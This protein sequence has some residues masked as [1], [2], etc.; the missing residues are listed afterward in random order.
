MAQ[1][2]LLI[3]T[4]HF[5]P[6]AASG[7]F[8]LLGFARHLPK[9]GWRALVVAPPRMPWE[10][11]DPELA[12]QVPSETAIYSVPYFEGRLTTPLRMWAS[13]TPW[14]VRAWPTCARAVR[15]HQP[16]AIL[17]S[18]PPHPIHMLGLWLKRR[19][20]LP[21]IADFRDPWIATAL[22]PPRRSVTSRWE[23][24]QER[25]VMASA[26]VIITNAPNA[27]EALAQAFPSAR[28]K[29]VV[30]T[31]GYDPE[32]FE[33]P[34]WTAP[35]A[36]DQP[37]TILHPG[38]LYAGRDP[39]P[40]LDALKVFRARR[41]EQARPIRLFL[42]GN[43]EGDHHS[44]DL[45]AEIRSRDL[46]AIV[47]VGGQ[48]PYDESLKRMVR[49]DILLLLDTPGRRIGVPAKLYEYVGAGRPVL[50]LGE[51]DG[52]TA[53]VLRQCGV[54][55]RIAPPGEPESIQQA[56][57]ELV[58]QV[59]SRRAAAVGAWGRLAFT[60]EHLARQLAELL[61]FR[62][63]RSSSPTTDEVE[64]GSNPAPAPAGAFA[65]ECKSVI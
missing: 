48:V 41:G 45:A 47:S 20:R 54:P 25:A 27:C 3:V 28:E 50:A 26:D 55:Y 10:P 49:S 2:S 57:A 59:E 44:F 5:P 15:E 65:G 31:N 16:A 35:G 12:K 58:E 39:R 1:R 7:S 18:G 33:S 37:I 23:A 46:Q 6:S 11:V 36:D 19:Y 60:R 62:T 42:I 63:A 21:W 40:F 9:F 38:Q 29:I 4:F 61:N 34:E 43:L 32:R 56:L 22:S 24:R 52:D 53:W 17:T 64:S 30:I 13:F 51:P 8:R 14:L